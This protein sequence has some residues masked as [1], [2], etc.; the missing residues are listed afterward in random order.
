M[1]I[2]LTKYDKYLEVKRNLDGEIEIS[3][4]SP[5]SSET[6][7]HI[8]TIKNQF[9]G[10][11]LW[12]KRDLMLM[13]NQRIDIINKVVKNNKKIKEFEEDDRMSRDVANL[14]LNDN[15]II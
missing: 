2:D 1:K 5:F 15:I 8:L 14:M 7:Y 3:R 11:L 6:R 4:N 9:I 13:D 12:I 10:S